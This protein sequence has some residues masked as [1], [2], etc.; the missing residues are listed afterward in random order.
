MKQ[1]QKIL[2]MMDDTVKDELA[3]NLHMVVRNALCG[4]VSCIKTQASPTG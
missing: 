3:K 1:S 4:P 2:K